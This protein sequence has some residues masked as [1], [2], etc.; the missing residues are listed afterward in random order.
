MIITY[1]PS[2]VFS[3]GPTLCASRKSLMQVADATMRSTGE[4]N[5][6]RFS[7]QVKL[8]SKSSYRAH[9]D[10]GI[11]HLPA[12]LH[13]VMQFSAL[14]TQAMWRFECIVIDKHIF[15]EAFMLM[16]AHAS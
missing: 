8:Q 5:A 7:L 15:C 10:A 14:Q 4:I 2:I 3:P 13:E 1:I 9:T 6:E 11:G 16:Q 12:G